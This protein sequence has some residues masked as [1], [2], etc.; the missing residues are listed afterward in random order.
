[1]TKKNVTKFD[2]LPNSYAEKTIKDVRIIRAAYKEGYKEHP[3]V[4]KITFEKH[5]RSGWIEFHDKIYSSV[6]YGINRANQ[7]FLEKYK[8]LLK[9]LGY[10]TDS[11][12]LYD[13]YCAICNAIDEDSV[14]TT[15]LKPF[16]DKTGLLRANPVK[17]KVIC[18]NIQVATVGTEN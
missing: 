16:I 11:V 13:V 5:T 6:K 2:F 4:L 18:K 14:I 15:T 1:M 8:L 17:V 12:D 9:I 10:K 3:Y 7:G